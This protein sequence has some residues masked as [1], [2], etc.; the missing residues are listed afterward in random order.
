MESSDRT[1]DLHAHTTASDGDLSPS[2]LVAL[3][4]ERGLTAVAVTDHD[5]VAGL[6]EALK[7]GARFG[8]EV[9]PGIELSAEFPR[10]QCHL[11]GL[12]LA[13][14]APDLCRRLQEVIDNRNRRN[15]RIVGKLNDLGVNIT[16]DDIVRVSGGEIVA[17]PHFARALIDRGVVASVQEAFDRFLAKGAAAYVERDRLT[18]Q[19][20]IDLIHRAGGVAILA[21]PNYLR[22]NEEQTELEIRNLAAL[23]LDGIEA[24][25]YNHTPEDTARYLDMAQRLGLLTSGGS[26]YHGPRLRPSVL[27]GQVEGQLPAPTALL[28]RLRPS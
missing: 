20:S 24:R 13:P 15:A 3:A 1:I 8:I 18:P 19:E 23:G 16:L 5:T 9:V 17:R 4:V 21:H 7:A 10:G 27:L 11:L 26:D 22:R 2:Q 12:F 6:D 28:D 25:Y 14:G